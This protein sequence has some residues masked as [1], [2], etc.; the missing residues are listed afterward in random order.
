MPDTGRSYVV[1]LRNLIAG[2]QLLRLI[3]GCGRVED[4]QPG[5]L[6]EW[7]GAD[8]LIHDI[9]DRARCQACGGRPIALQAPADLPDDYGGGRGTE[10]PR[11]PEGTP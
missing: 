2:R 5:P 3:C 1:T 7:H 11:D 8:T 6:A 9:R 10:T 4:L